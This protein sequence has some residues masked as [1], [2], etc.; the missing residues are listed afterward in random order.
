VSGHVC[1]RQELAALLGVH[2][3]SV[4][5]WLDAYAAGGVE[6]MLS[7]QLRHIETVC[8]K[9]KEETTLL[10]PVDSSRFSIHHPAALQKMQ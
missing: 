5:A 8:I 9:M 2:R 3:H 1:S 10:C 6:K 4:A 7:Y